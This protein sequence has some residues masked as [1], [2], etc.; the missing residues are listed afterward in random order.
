[1]KAVVYVWHYALLVVHAREEE[2]D[3]SLAVLF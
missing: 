2:E 1:M 3:L